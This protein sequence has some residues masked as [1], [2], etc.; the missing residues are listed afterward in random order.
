MPEL[1]LI[2]LAIEIEQQQQPEMQ[3][4]GDRPQIE[5]D[6]GI[7]RESE[8]RGGSRL[9]VNVNHLLVPDGGKTVS[10]VTYLKQKVTYL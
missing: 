3:N 2:Y 7:N 4:G 9:N 6:R 8:G 10:Q 1:N 5:R